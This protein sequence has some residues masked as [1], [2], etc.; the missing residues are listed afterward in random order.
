VTLLEEIAGERPSASH[1]DDVREEVRAH[2]LRMCAIRRGSLLLAPDYG[3]D[4]P[5]YL[6]HSFPG[7]LDEWLGHLAD[8]LARYEPRLSDARVMPRPAE[9]LD[10]TLRFEIQGTLTVRDRTEPTQFTAIVDPLQ[11]WSVR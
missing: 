3:M 11:H 10:L 1:P 5:T 6:F 7:G 8:A 9:E 2:L 4:D